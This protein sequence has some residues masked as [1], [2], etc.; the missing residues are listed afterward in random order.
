M[1]AS[2]PDLI[3]LISV[4]VLGWA[5]VRDLRT[6]RVPN[7]IWWPL[8]VLGLALITWNAYTLLGTGFPLRLYLIRVALSVGIVVPL[9]Y[10]FWYLGGFGGADA[11]AFMVLAVLFPTFPTYELL[12]RTLPIVVTDV[13]VFS[14][15][16][17][18]NTV[19]V[20]LAFPLALAVR[21]LLGGDISSLM[22]LGRRVPVD[23]LPTEYGTLLE[24]PSGMT[25]NG[26]DLDALRMYL[27]WRGITL[28]DIQTRPELS[29]PST[30]PAEPND[31]TDGAVHVDGGESD[32]VTP[33]V[34][35]QSVRTRNPS[36]DP[37]SAWEWV[38]ASDQFPGQADERTDRK[39]TNASAPPSTVA[40]RWGA[41]AFLS[42]IDSSAYG[43]TPADLRE[44]LD[45]IV[46]ADTVWVSPG[47]PF[48]VPT[49][50]GLLIALGFGDLLFFGLRILGFV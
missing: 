36:P 31:P 50:V 37:Q 2:I 21:N 46:D 16:V 10:G 9:S 11:K 27:R 19:I 23:E 29:D 17:L 14:L 15:S 26:L 42:D 34:D 18:T 35:G 4:P 43:T 41:D 24:T 38:E 5:A 20:G 1:Q 3:R 33:A 30:L 22:F 6:R 12:G 28:E 45:V 8:S 25:R 39:A 32:R 40:D 49:F 13:G 7:T 47:I 48:I 44:G